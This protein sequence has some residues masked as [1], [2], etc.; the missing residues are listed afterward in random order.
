MLLV[1]RQGV[2]KKYKPHLSTSEERSRMVIAD[3]Q[4]N[5]GLSGVIFLLWRLQIRFN[6]TPTLDLMSMSFGSWKH[7]GNCNHTGKIIPR[8]WNPNSDYSA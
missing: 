6:L 5:L 2:D 7:P 3:A 1:V 8:Q 4:S